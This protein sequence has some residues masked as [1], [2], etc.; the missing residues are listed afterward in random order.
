M[1]LFCSDSTDRVEIK[2]FSFLL[3][4]KDKA[5]LMGEHSG[6]KHAGEEM[7]FSLHHPWVFCSQSVE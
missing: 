1:N 7:S 4:V 5:A 3:L 2:R 6:L